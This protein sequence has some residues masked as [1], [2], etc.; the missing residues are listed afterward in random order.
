MSPRREAAA[1]GAR[2]GVGCMPLELA[3]LKSATPSAQPHAAPS[4]HSNAALIDLIRIV[5]SRTPARLEDIGHPKREPERQRLLRLNRRQRT[6]C[7]AALPPR[8]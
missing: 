8:D 7:R 6:P 4:T 1:L 5:S 2:S 3:Q